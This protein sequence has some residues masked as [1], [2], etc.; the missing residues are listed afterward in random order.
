MGQKTYRAAAIGHTGAGNYGH[1]LHIAYKN[2]A[3]VEFVAVADPDDAGRKKAV[4]ETGAQRD[5]ADY[6][7]MLAKEDLDIVSVCPRWIPAHLEMVPACLD[8]GCH[9]YCEKPMTATLADG[10]AIVRAAKEKGL[11][12]A[13]AHQQ[14][15]SPVTQA[16]K[17]KLAEGIIGD[18]QAIYVHGKQD[19]RGGGEDMITL[20]T[21]TFN[22]MRFLV[23]D[24]DWMH[25]HITVNGRE[26]TIDDAWEGSEPVGPVAGDCVNSYFAF[27]SGVS[28]LYDSRKDQFGRGGTEIL[29]SEG[30][31]LPGGG[32]NSV[33][34]Y[35]DVGWSPRDES[36]ER[37]LV[38]IC[39][40]PSV[41]GDGIT[42][43]N[44]LA[45]IDLIGAIENDRKP[46]SSAED[47]VAALEMIVGGYESQLTGARVEFP[48]KNREHPLKRGS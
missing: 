28:G 34:I 11:K 8:A 7:D 43:G 1:G 25:A 19:G 33:T 9:I 44:Q 4:E 41:E 45:I 14:V 13:V 26:I 48:I 5:Y 21:H 3:N 29:G 31:L 23:G 39:D 32:P 27:K 40:P 37:K 16:L 10:D 38:E 15:Y 42:S 2:L 6:R 12:I 36:Q 17:T 35:P 22:M 24:V 20:G 18:V 30:V 47:A 46:V